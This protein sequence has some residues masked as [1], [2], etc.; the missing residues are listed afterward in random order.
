MA[1]LT[2]KTGCGDYG[3]AADIY[4]AEELQRE[5]W[6]ILNKLGKFEDREEEE[7]AGA[8]SPLPFEEANRDEE[9]YWEGVKQNCDEV[10]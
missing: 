9:G 2:R 5:T 6:K 7:A 4:T 10:I 3:F 1:R 8:Y